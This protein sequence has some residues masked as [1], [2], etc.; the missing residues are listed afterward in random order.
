M[1]SEGL[2]YDRVSHAD[3][4][5]INVGDVVDVAYAAQIRYHCQA[6]YYVNGYV[7]SGSGNEYTVCNKIRTPLERA[8]AETFFFV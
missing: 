8:F 3:D 2:F 6:G 5:T 1:L 4:T 7:G